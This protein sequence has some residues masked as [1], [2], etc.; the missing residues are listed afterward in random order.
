MHVTPAGTAAR[1][2]IAALIAALVALLGLGLATA[3]AQAAGT[4]VVTAKIE[5]ITSDDGYS[6]VSSNG[7]IPPGKYIGGYCD[8]EDVV[9]TV[10]GDANGQWRYSS[11]VHTNGCQTV[12]VKVFHLDWGIEPNDGGTLY[13]IIGTLPFKA[14]QELKWDGA[15]VPDTP[16]KPGE[17]A[18]PAE[19]AQPA[20]PAKP[21][22]PAPANPE[23]PATPD[24]PA[25]S[26]APGESAIVARCQTSGS[27]T[28]PMPA[29]TPSSSTSAPSSAASGSDSGFTA[30]ATAFTASG[31]GDLSGTGR[32]GNWVLIRDYR[33]NI[34]THV[35]VGDDG[36]WS[37]K[38]VPGLCQDLGNRTY[39][40]VVENARDGH[41][42]SVSTITGPITYA[43]SAKANRDTSARTVTL[44][45]TAS[46][47]ATIIIYAVT[48]DWHA[49]K[50]LLAGRDGTWRVE[51]VPGLL[52]RTGDNYIVVEQGINGLHAGLRILKVDGPA[53]KAPAAPKPTSTA[54]AAKPTP[55]AP[56]STPAPAKSCAPNASIC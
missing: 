51:N 24:Q 43:F 40:I 44:T 2:V 28:T 56:K 6:K 1:K 18:E 42:V 39:R 25:T 50:T 37:A 7:T 54:P 46:P 48:N 3:P 10:Y 19:P 26:P 12:T 47:G 17:P 22:A 33:W 35:I 49:K 31:A 32:P 13:T 5:S 15:G 4:P 8:N 29:E 45:G 53:A 36:R 38:N 30:K 27:V 21:A 11:T 9:F 16:A 23:T 14:G 34:K 55:A 41:E 20:E 52:P